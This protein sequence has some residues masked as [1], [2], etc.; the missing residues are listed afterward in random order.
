MLHLID[1][2]SYNTLTSEQ[3]QMA[4]I[5]SQTISDGSLSFPLFPVMHFTAAL[6]DRQYFP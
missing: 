5:S 1:Y 3:D 6:F 2:I 4:D